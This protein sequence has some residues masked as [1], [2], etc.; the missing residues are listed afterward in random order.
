M[1]RVDFH[2][3]VLYLHTLLASSLP[4]HISNSNDNGTFLMCNPEVKFHIHLGTQL[5]L[6]W[7]TVSLKINAKHFGH[8]I[9][10][11]NKCMDVLPIDPLVKILILCVCTC[12]H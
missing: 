9:F 3:K 11:P 8:G 4:L 10:Y 2:D 7:E 6:F 1:S 12:V 5:L